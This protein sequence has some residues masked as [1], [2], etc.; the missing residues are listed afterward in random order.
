MVNVSQKKLDIGRYIYKY[1]VEI[2]EIIR[3]IEN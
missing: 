2:R 3:N 1:E